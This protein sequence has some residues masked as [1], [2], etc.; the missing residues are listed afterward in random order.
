MFKRK[1]I[2]T[3]VLKMFDCLF[4][5]LFMIEHVSLRGILYSHL[6][7]SNKPLRFFIIHFTSLSRP[8]VEN[9]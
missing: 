1:N 8:Y 5:L 7:Y 2:F 9:A 3:L 6:Y 4:F